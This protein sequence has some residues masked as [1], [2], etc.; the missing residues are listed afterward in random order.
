MSQKCKAYEPR[1]DESGMNGGR[2]NRK[3]LFLGVHRSLEDA[4]I[5]LPICTVQVNYTFAPF[6][7]NIYNLSVS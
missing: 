6:V 3:M 7:G 1:G 4:T 5:C 2:D